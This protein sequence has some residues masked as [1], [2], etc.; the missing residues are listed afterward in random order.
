MNRKRLY[1]TVE[2]KEEYKALSKR[3]RLEGKPSHFQQRIKTEP[4]RET[5][6]QV[7]GQI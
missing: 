4:K 7:K 5:T 6:K 1:M 3:Y 2:E